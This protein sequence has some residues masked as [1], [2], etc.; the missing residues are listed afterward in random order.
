MTG[1]AS[2]VDDCGVG[3][4]IGDGLRIGVG[5]DNCPGFCVWI[6]FVFIRGKGLC[7]GA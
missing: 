6:S 1:T 7:G 3:C 4:G 5:P 2:V